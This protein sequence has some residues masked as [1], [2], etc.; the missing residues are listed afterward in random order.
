MAKPKM[1]RT[2]D[3]HIVKENQSY[4]LVINIAGLVPRCRKIHTKKYNPVYGLK[5]YKSINI[6]CHDNPFYSVYRKSHNLF[7]FKNKQKAMNKLKT[8]A[9]YKLGVE[10]RLYRQS[11]EKLREII[12]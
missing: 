10:T 6:K 4:Y 8:L 1:L 12:K 5:R 7:I 3:N 9:R 2:H 11:V